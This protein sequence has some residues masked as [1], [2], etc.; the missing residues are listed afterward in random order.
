MTT[1]IILGIDVGRVLIA[2]QSSERPDTSFI[3]GSLEDAL[4][5][6]PYE[7]MFAHLPTLIERFA[8]RA[9]LVSKAGPRVQ[10]KTRHWLRHHRFHERTGVPADSVHFCRERHQKASICARLRVTHFIDDRTD[11]LHHLKGVVTHRYLFGPQRRGTL[12]P[13]GVT[14]VADWAAVVEAVLHDLG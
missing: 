6:P 11:V 3:G 10:D 5:T 12:A 1:N 13:A 8:G 14:A 4:Q 7:G 9:C 2:P